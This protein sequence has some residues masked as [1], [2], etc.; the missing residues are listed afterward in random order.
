[1]YSHTRELAK[2]SGKKDAWKSACA[3]LENQLHMARYAYHKQTLHKYK[4]LHVMP[5]DQAAEMYRLTML[6][7]DALIEG[8]GGDYPTEAANEAEMEKGFDG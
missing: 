7:Y 8:A 1:M 6:N 4:V 5:P 3:M 2:E